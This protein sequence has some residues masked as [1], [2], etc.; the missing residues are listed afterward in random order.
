MK[1]MIHKTLIISLLSLFASVYA[2]AEPAF[3]EVLSKSPLMAKHLYSNQIQ[4]ESKV[5]D[6]VIYTRQHPG[7]ET[8]GGFAQVLQQT[9]SKYDAKLAKEINAYWTFQIRLARKNTGS[10]WHKYAKSLP[11]GVQTIKRRKPSRW[12]SERVTSWSDTQ[13]FKV[14]VY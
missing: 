8:E 4:Q 14:L 2:S 1:K 13:E 10:K 5:S 11:T 9:L 3:H 6:G 7:G 12:M